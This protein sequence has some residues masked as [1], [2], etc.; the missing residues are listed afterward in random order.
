M[1]KADAIMAAVGSIAE[2]T[3]IFFQT[4][5]KNGIPQDAATEITEVFIHDLMLV[6]FG[7]GKELE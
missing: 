4:L 2:I 6:S 1:N 5:V 7:M 3:S